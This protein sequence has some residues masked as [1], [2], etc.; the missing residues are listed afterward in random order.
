[1]LKKNVRSIVPAIVLALAL[2]LVACGGGAAAPDTSDDGATE[3]ETTDEEASGSDIRVGVVLD[4]GGEND[5]NFNEYTLAGVRDAANELGIEFNYVVSG[6]PTEYERNIENLI[7]EGHEM[8]VTVGFLMGEA[9]QAAAERH[10]DVSFAIVDVDFIDLP[11]VTGLVFAEDEVGFLAGALAGCMTETNTVSTVSGVDVP[12]VVKFVT[13]YQNG[14]L[15]ANPDVETLNVYIPSFTDPTAG[16]QAGEEQIANGSDV[17]FGVGGGTGNGGLLAAHEA[18]LMAIGVDVD[19]YFTYEEVQSSLLTS[20]AK[21]MDVAAAQAVRDYVNGELEPGNRL[22][23][24]ENG[25]VGLAPFHE[26]EDRIQERGCDV[27]AEEA[28]EGLLSGELT[29][30][31]EPEG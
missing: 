15:W 9:T 24:L 8:I 31:Y 21:N 17:I 22:S 5:K 27:V 3:A 7:E 2:T 29:T 14:A 12:A 16:K 28:R 6:A 25:G 26:W 11:N 1:M 19:Q 23:N 30:G 18:G 20:A 10:P 4:T 13:G